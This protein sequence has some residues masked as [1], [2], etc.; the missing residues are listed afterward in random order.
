M[1]SLAGKVAIVTGAAGGQGAA[2]AALLVR[3]G[4]AVLLTDIAEPDV[5][6]LSELG[7]RAA[8]VPHDV[9]CS[10]D[11]DRVVAEAEARFG[12][13]DILVNNAGIFVAAAI[14]DTSPELFERHYRVNQ[15]GVF[16]GMRAVVPAMKR[17]GGGAIINIASVGA[18][19]GY[20]GEFAYCASKWAVRGMTR[21]AAH[22]LAP[23]G[24]RVNT[25]MPGAID[26][27][28]LGGMD[29]QG[30]WIDHIP[31]RRI[32]DAEEIAETVAFLASEAAQFM[33]G[34][35]VVVDG[36]MLA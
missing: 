24:I 1:M 8:F 33:T 5:E 15:L 27:P 31:L 29:E 13:L 3:R 4:A 2:E 12:A 16:L 30:Q 19:R 14:G 20:P 7:D 26:T 17:R 18:A 34:S 32:G 6:V 23:F 25:V 28:M 35:E 11:W 22:D 21:C 10:T 36:G 9:A